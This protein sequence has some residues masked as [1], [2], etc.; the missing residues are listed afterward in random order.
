MPALAEDDRPR[1]RCPPFFAGLVVV[2]ATAAAPSS[3]QEAVEPAPVAAPAYRRV[4]VPAERPELWPTRGERYLPI[5]T[6]E[7]AE[8]LRPPG[9]AP[10]GRATITSIALKARVDQRG[11]LVGEGELEVEA[12]AG[13]AGYFD[14]PNQTLAIR[15]AHWRG[16]APTEPMLGVWNPPQGVAGGPRHG[17]FARQSGVLAFEFEAPPTPAANPTEFV[18]PLPEST[19]RSLTLSLAPGTRPVASD[20][21]LTRRLASEK[22]KNSWLLQPLTGRR[23][24]FRVASDRPAR[25]TSNDAAYV[26]ATLQAHAGGGGVE[27]VSELRLRSDRPLPNSVRISLPPGATLSHASVDGIA[28]PAQAEPDGAMIDLADRRLPCEAMVTLTSWAPAGELPQLNGNVRWT[29]KPPQVDGAVF[30]GGTAS[31][32]ADRELR[33]ADAAQ[34]SGAVFLTP[35]PRVTQSEAADGNRTLA[36][37][38]LRADASIELAL[39]PFNP[40]LLTRLL[41]SSELG[42]TEVRSRVRVTASRTAASVKPV[43]LEVG[44]E[45]VVEAV[46]AASGRGLALVEDWRIV[47]I[48]GR[49]QLTIQLAPGEQSAP[50][51]DSALTCTVSCRRP[52]PDTRELPLSRAAPLSSFG[53]AARENRLAVTAALPFGLRVLS[54]DAAGPESRIGRERGDPVESVS[55][56][57]LDAASN[58]Y[59][60]ATT[61]SLRRRTRRYDA[62]IDVAVNLAGERAA[63]RAQ[64][65]LLDDGDRPDRVALYF[66]P[67]LPKATRWVDVVTGGVL[68][69]KR[70]P[71]DGPRRNGGLPGEH[72]L[73][74]SP[75]RG[76]VV[77]RVAVEAVLPTSPTLVPLAMA[78]D[79]NNQSATVK[80]VGLGVRGWGVDRRGVWPTPSDASDTLAYRYNPRGVT[81]FRRT[82]RLSV[83]PAATL[84]PASGPNAPVHLEQLTSV[85]GG[86]DEVLHTARYKSRVRLK[87]LLI[88]LPARIEVLSAIDDRGNR[89]PVSQAG[90]NAANRLMGAGVRTLTVTLPAETAI[91]SGEW[92][93]VSVAYREPLLNSRQIP[94]TLPVSTA[95]HHDWQWVVRTPTRWDA[96]GELRLGQRLFSRLARDGSGRP[97]NP[98]EADEWRALLRAGGS[99]ARLVRE[100]AQR[101]AGYGDS[102]PTE[103]TRLSGWRDLVFQGADT[104]PAPLRLVDLRWRRAQGLAIILAVAS[105]AAWALVPR[106]KLHLALALTTLIGALLTPSGGAAIASAVWMGLLLAWPYAWLFRMAQ[107]RRRHNKTSNKPAGTIGRAA[108]G[109]P[110]A[111]I[112]VILAAAASPAT[113]EDQTPSGAGLPTVLIPVDSEG[114]L[115]GDRHFLPEEWLRRRLRQQLRGQSTAPSSV[116]VKHVRVRGE[117]AVDQRTG[118][119]KPARWSLELDLHTLTRRATIELPLTRAEAEWSPT[120]SIDG[121]PTPLVWLNDRQC[122]FTVTEPGDCHA[123]L[124]FAPATT[125]LGSESCVRLSLPKNPG[126][127]LDLAHPGSLRSVRAPGARSVTQ[128]EPGRLVATLDQPGDLRVCWAEAALNDADA[129]PTLDVLQLLNITQ[130][131]VTADVRILGME[132]GRVCLVPVPFGWSSVD[133]PGASEVEAR[134]LVPENAVAGATPRRVRLVLQRQS[135]LGTI[136]VPSINVVGAAVNRQLAGAKV[137][138]GL[139]RGVTE[140]PGVSVLE[141]REFAS[142]WDSA[143]GPVVT[144][145]YSAQ[146]AGGADWRLMID[147]ESIEGPSPRPRLDLLVGA[148]D[149]RLRLSVEGWRPPSPRLVVCVPPGLEVQAV[150]ASTAD[151]DTPIAWSRPEPERLVLFRPPGGAPPSGTGVAS[152]FEVQARMPRDPQEESFVAPRLSLAF[153]PDGVVETHVFRTEAVRV[154]TGGESVGGPAPAPP[155]WEARWVTTRL[156]DARD[157]FRLQVSRNTPTTRVVSVTSHRLRGGFVSARWTAD[158]RVVD[159]L[160]GSPV[161]SFAL[162]DAESVEVLSPPGAALADARPGSPERRLRLAEAVGSG[163]LVRLEIEVRRPVAGGGDLPAPFA[164]LLGADSV[165][166]YVAVPSNDSEADPPLGE[167][168]V[169]GLG[170]QTSSP[171]P[172]LKLLLP[173]SHWRLFVSPGLGA[174]AGGGGRVFWPAARPALAE[175]ACP[176]AEQSVV[177]YPGVEPLVTTRFAL[178]PGGADRCEVTLPDGYQLKEATING[179]NAYASAL[180]TRGWHIEL[181]DTQAPQILQLI[182]LAPIGQ[183]RFPLP[184]LATPTQRAVAPQRTL[185]A[186]ADGTGRTAPASDG[187]RPISARTASFLR[188]RALEPLATRGDAVPEPWLDYWRALLAKAAWQAR[189]HDD[190]GVI[191]LAAEPGDADQARLWEESVS[192]YYAR[193][194]AWLQGFPPE[195]DTAS[196]APGTAGREWRYFEVDAADPNVDPIVSRTAAGDFPA[197][198]ALALAALALLLAA[199]RRCTDAD[200]FVLAHDYRHAIAAVGGV[201]WWLLLEP[202]FFGLVLLTASVAGQL[203]VLVGEH[204]RM[205]A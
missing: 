138:P 169:L 167:W 95:T 99:P 3:A 183:E 156:V 155:G 124:A 17:L 31:V 161:L 48:D 58:E 100:A 65:E 84:S 103:A 75:S 25:L 174:R 53:E 44:D 4:F 120:V 51:D 116:L 162:R 7:L 26:T 148:E 132:D 80:L 133:S 21:L 118:V 60:G 83:N 199:R 202:S 109:A 64:F 52:M 22:D 70:T 136:R 112:V 122:T 193:A 68:S 135:P 204:W 30:L 114:D 157:P 102:P 140:S 172:S 182:A 189:R 151:G 82:T 23:L 36:L 92:R 20:A 1:R 164:R 175:F 2:V 127:G 34:P 107:A 8:L 87:K 90:A 117:L 121:V 88:A 56:D 144:P 47:E 46:E 39:E 24:V 105:A 143:G 159:G 163:G 190:D 38:L 9:D 108:A 186:V 42:G 170:E 28:I 41:Q 35:G 59:A 195:I 74:R 146:L 192:A 45:W 79:A 173:D 153:S 149:V 40:P 66:E 197:R 165:E 200:L 168:S 145:D 134:A 69:A 5:E 119:V 91:R 77:T 12:P 55:L 11:V 71:A 63:Y 147:P 89:L 126:I 203:K 32:V 194:R 67:P 158:I 139:R 179:V 6:A 184:G 160:L 97:F 54:M 15:R 101:F 43:R 33:I 125:K 72:W 27:V 180:S 49:R 150:T 78:P 176:F 141:P 166:Q 50:T 187:V 110:T 16:P 73:L 10:N 129:A 94:P 29:L 188:L 57:L 81:D 171:S 19:N 142:R 111:I 198:L 196:S 85:W 113:A 137:G 123:T 185:W 177:A 18:I 178:S 14:W 205:A 76:S 131:G 115:V 104:P 154:R 13:D 181:R 201:L 86:G 62:L 93:E 98:L 191:E 128:S 152:R 106:P 61:I 96:A 130:E 37:R